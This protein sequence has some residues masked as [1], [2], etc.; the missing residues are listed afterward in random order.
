[1]RVF[2]RIWPWATRQ[3]AGLVVF[4]YVGK[5]FLILFADRSTRTCSRPSRMPRRR[6]R[7][8]AVSYLNSRPLVEGLSDHF[9]DWEVIWDVPSRLADRLAAGQLDVGLI[10]SIEWLQNPRYIR[11]SDACIGCRGPVLSVKLLSRVP[12]AR[13]RTLALDEG[14]RTSAFLV[15]ILL[16]ER[17]GIRPERIRLPLDCQPDACEADALL[18]IGDR[19][20]RPAQGDYLETWDLGQQW[21]EWSGLPFVFAVWAARPGVPLTDLAS[22]LVI[23]RD[24]GLKNLERIVSRHADATGLS[25]QQAL[26]YLRD[27]LHFFFGAE[28]QRGLQRFA[29]CVSDFTAAI[30]KE[31]LRR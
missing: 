13:I 22:G 15:Q 23:A 2:C 28:Q 21:W 6:L 30:A 24:A 19:A 3:R 17:F 29:Q 11:V 31:G 14:S 10:P 7:I 9:P 12:I 27:N 18:V 26:C 1:M 5:G 4:L 25:R 8:G 20:I 16:W